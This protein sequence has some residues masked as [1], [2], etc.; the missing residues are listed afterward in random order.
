EYVRLEDGPTGY[1]GGLYPSGSNERPAAHVAAGLALAQQVTPLNFAGEPDPGGRIVMISVGMSNAAME[2]RALIDLFRAD[3][4]RHPQLRLI[5]GA[6][7]GQIA[8]DWT[9]PNAP[10]WDNVD[11]LIRD[12]GLHPNQV[13]VAWIKNVRTGGGDFPEK[14]ET[15]QADLAAIARA[16]KVRYPNVRLAYLSSRTRGYTYWMGL[17][18]EPAAFESGFAVKWLVAQ[19]IAGDPALNYDPAAGPVVAPFLAWGPYLWADGLNPR[20]DGLVWPQE[21]LV[22]DCTHPSDS[23]VAKVAAQ[24]L[25]FFK[26]DS[27]TQPWFLANPPQPPPPP[28]PPIIHY[29]P[30]LGGISD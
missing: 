11:Q 15:L 9:D 22:A 8:T 18:P 27:T 6:Q 13:Q 26:T 1:D 21:D 5:N 23:G 17:S 19:Q 16:L 29:L 28:P 24:L 25:D 10:T 14:A 3:P 12:F 30:L 7:P 4:D 2:F 20:A